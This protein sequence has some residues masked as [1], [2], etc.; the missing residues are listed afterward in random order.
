[1]TTARGR[2]LLNLPKTHLH[3][4]LEGA[5]RRAT[6]AELAER[7][8]GEVPLGPGRFGGFQDF[9]SLYRTASGLIRTL[10]D[11][12]RVMYEVVEDAHA[13]GAIWLEPAV[14]VPNH[15][16]LGPHEV[17]LEA[18]LDAARSAAAATGTGVGLIVALDR[19]LPPEIELDQARL[20]VKYAEAGVVALGLASD[21]TAA[22]PERFEAAFRLA[23]EAGLLATPHAGEHAGPRSVR[24]ALDALGA[25]RVQHGVRAVEDRDLVCRLADQ[26]VCLDVAPT[27]NASLGVVTDLADHPLPQLLTAGVACSV[28]ADDPLLFGSGLAGEYL[29]CRDVLGLDDAALAG[30]ARSSVL[31]SGAPEP[32][33]RSAEAEIDRWLECPPE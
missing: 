2:S 23:R 10:D 11:L 18:L 28:N 16:D 22:P 21:E 29:L 26:G 12:Q 25:D 24:S 1:M 4:H 27:S 7:Y 33:K 20:A 8:G 30:C 6:L 31:H 3:V 19:T 15:D 14:H 9:V 13:D 32:L 17:V 5:M